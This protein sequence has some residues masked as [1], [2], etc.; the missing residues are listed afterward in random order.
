[1]TNLS[2]SDIDKYIS[3][4]NDYE[5]QIYNKGINIICSE[6]YKLLEKCTL[7]MENAILK[8]DFH[9]KIKPKQTSLY[10]KNKDTY[11]KLAT[12]KQCEEMGFKTKYPIIEIPLNDYS[13][14]VQI[15]NKMPSKIDP[16]AKLIVQH[17]STSNW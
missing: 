9:Y 13:D 14:C 11:L 1:M 17:D 16:T 3:Q 8:N 15:Y 5:Q 4:K 7:E 10:W 6:I 12:I 2:K